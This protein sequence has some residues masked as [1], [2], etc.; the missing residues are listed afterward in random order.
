MLLEIV[1]VLIAVL[2]PLALK[3]LI[4]L[5]RR[6]SRSHAK[7]LEDYQFIASFLSIDIK[8]RE[9]L[10]VEQAF[11][12]FFRRRYSFETIEM[13]IQFPNPMKAFRL[14]NWA[15]NFIQVEDGVIRAKQSPIYLKRLIVVKWILYITLIMC[16][17]FPLLYAPMIIGHLGI[18]A[19]LQIMV[20]SVVAGANGVEQ[21]LALA[22]IEASKILLEEQGKRQSCP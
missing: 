17:V 18:S 8:K 5:V 19:F 11:Y 12:V 22:A 9:R 1:K 7:L 4:D 13:L 20:L 15:F 2:T 6:G 16:A 3:F 21:L 10:V 14:F